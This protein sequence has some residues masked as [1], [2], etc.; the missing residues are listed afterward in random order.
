MSNRISLLFIPVFGFSLASSLAQ[1]PLAQT[2]ADIKSKDAEMS[3]AAE[4][5]VALVFQQELPSIEKDTQFL[6]GSLHDGNVLV[7]RHAAALLTA[8]VLAAP[9]HSQVDVACFPDL[10][11]A[12]GDTDDTT[13]NDI[14]YVLAMTPGGPPAA[15]REVFVKD[16][17]SPN[18]RTSEVA[19]AGLLK[20]GAEHKQDNEM[21]VKAKLDNAPDEKQ[22]LNLLY[23]IAG[24]GV[25]SAALL[26]S[27]RK[28]LVDSDPQVQSAAFQ[29]VSAT[30]TKA[31]VAEIMGDV[32]ASPSSSPQAKKTARLLLGRQQPSLA[33]QNH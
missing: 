29:A 32:A 5:N 26:E 15:A 1:T 19:A 9:E 22:R 24:S 3:A 30:G 13:R 18:Y 6:C 25:Q 2:F 4:R 16:L 31:E 28:F 14:L 21:L 7:R 10:V 11:A 23:A 20:I 12:S 8:I 17:D 27:S 33:G